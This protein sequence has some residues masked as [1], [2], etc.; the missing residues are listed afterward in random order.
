MKKIKS[1]IKDEVNT[2]KDIIKAKLKQKLEFYDSIKPTEEQMKLSSKQRID[3][4]QYYNNFSLDL[5]NIILELITNPTNEL[6]RKIQLFLL[7]QDLTM[8]DLDKPDIKR[9]L[10]SLLLLVSYAGIKSNRASIIKKKDKGH[11]YDSVIFTNATNKAHDIRRIIQEIIINFVYNNAI[12]YL[13]DSSYP[14]T[15][16]ESKT[17]FDTKGYELAIKLNHS[18][19]NLYEKEKIHKDL[20]IKTQEDAHKKLHDK[21][22][23]DLLDREKLETDTKQKIKDKAILKAKFIKNVY[24][25]LRAPKT[26]STPITPIPIT[27][28]IIPATPALFTITTPP[29]TPPATTPTTTPPTTPTA[30][31]SS[32]LGFTTPPVIRKRAK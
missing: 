18:K 1:I 3:F 31:A 21:Y 30:T 4:S 29:S 2:I 5:E 20:F 6:V 11:Q 25:Y 14:K 7:K 27:P 10:D 26:P 16:I 22:I 32:V 19:G 13:Q 17:M 23:Q 15:F 24:K 12:K 28:I 9:I 8:N